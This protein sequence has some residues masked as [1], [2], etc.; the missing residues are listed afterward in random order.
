MLCSYA[1]LLCCL[2]FTICPCLLF[3]PCQ[4]APSVSLLSF[5]THTLLLSWTGFLWKRGQ[6][7]SAG[8]TWLNKDFFLFFLIALSL[9]ADK[10]PLTSRQK[11]PTQSWTVWS[12]TIV[13]L[14]KTQK[15][16]AL[17]TTSRGSMTSSLKWTAEGN[18]WRTEVWKL[19]QRIWNKSI[20]SFE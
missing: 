9:L 6:C 19:S 17:T 1:N 4:G 16:I 5:S 3:C 10:L 8:P 11:L 13:Q 2:D 20:V 18:T 12:P 14:F 7:I 15:C